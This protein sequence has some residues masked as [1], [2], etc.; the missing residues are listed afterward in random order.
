MSELIPL[1]S[2]FSYFAII[3]FKLG[4]NPEYWFLEGC[5][6]VFWTHEFAFALAGRTPKSSTLATFEMLVGQLPYVG[7]G[8][9]DY[10]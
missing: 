4:I 1:S 7:Y 9:G 10:G 3:A 6:I 5:S 2:G 8:Y